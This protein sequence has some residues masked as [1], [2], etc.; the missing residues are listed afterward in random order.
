MHARRLA[1]AL[2]VAGTALAGCADHTT[3]PP[4]LRVGT[5]S[6]SQTA[7][8]TQYVV[9]ARTTLPAGFAQ[10]VAAAGGEVV[11]V[12]PEI[13]MAVVT[14]SAPGFAAALSRN[15]A[16]EQVTPDVT[17]DWQRPLVEVAL[18]ETALEFAPG[19]ESAV[20]DAEQF[21]FLQWGPDAVDAPLAWAAG[22]TGAGARVAVLDGGLNHLH[23]DI[24]ANVDV[25]A[26]RSFVPGFAFNQDVSSHANHV[27]GIIAAAQNGIGSIGIAPN[28]TIIGVKVL[29]Q[30]SGSFS[31]L[32]AAIVY[33]ATP[34]AEG[35]AGAHL[36][37]MSLGA[38]IPAHRGNIGNDLKAAIR[39]LNQ[40]LERAIQYAYTRGVTVIAS[41][42]NEGLNLDVETDVMHVP[43]MN[44]RA[45]SI[46]ATGPLGWALGA[47]D[48][49]R[50]ASY[51]NSGRKG[52][53][54]AAPGG[55]FALPGEDLCI[56]WGPV[57]GIQNAC[58]VFDMYL[59]HSRTGYSWSAGTSMAAPVAAGIAALII[60][61]EGGN[62]SAALVEARLKQGA[63][64]LGKRGNDEVYG[65][66]WLN[67]Y[68][69]IR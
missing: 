57:F 22:I 53:S 10:D 67:A 30:G 5:A 62:A 44:G 17:V 6:F 48:F 46:A 36:I 56:V 14:S 21:G 69:S 9:L 55:D 41:A 2:L 8:G 49:E 52:V 47:T 59:S 34:V 19:E 26:S 7:G 63:E 51:T 24:A 33:A 20:V 45:I 60:E 38:L 32:P 3:A 58:W 54:L 16:I 64:D 28:A 66:G 15:R 31:W 18:D 37:N 65:H 35:G 4:E 1:A 50:Q 12:L 61:A 42:G 11:S 13:G 25:A 23:P 39:E 29:H 27:A 40:S 68:R 43:S